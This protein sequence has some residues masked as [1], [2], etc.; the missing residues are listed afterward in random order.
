M[1]LATGIAIGVAIGVAI[2]AAF[3]NIAMGIG[4]GIAIGIAIA[5]GA[6]PYQRRKLPARSLV[7]GGIRRAMT[8]R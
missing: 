6:T 2:G 8:A 3:G 1:S 4:I 5:G 7:A